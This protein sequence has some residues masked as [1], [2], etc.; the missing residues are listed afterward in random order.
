MEILLQTPAYANSRGLSVFRCRL[1]NPAV[2][3]FP[4][5]LFA[6]GVRFDRISATEKAGTSG[7]MRQDDH[8]RTA[9]E[10]SGVDVYASSSS[11]R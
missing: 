4:A 5:K 9:N 10:D 11:C 3:V 6:T 8:G 7:L 2:G 1:M